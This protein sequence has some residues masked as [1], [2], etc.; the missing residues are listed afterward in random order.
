MHC[1]LSKPVCEIRRDP[2]RRLPSCHMQSSPDE[3]RGGVGWGGRESGGRERE[4][5]F[6]G[7]V[8]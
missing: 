2:A 5:A 3:D 4:D 8:F 1:Q 6:W 7:R